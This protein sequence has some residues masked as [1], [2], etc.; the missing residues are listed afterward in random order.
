MTNLHTSLIQDARTA[1]VNRDTVRSQTLQSLL[2]R[3]SNMEA[4]EMVPE[5]EVTEAPRNVLSEAEVIQALNDEIA[6][7]SQAI[8]VLQG[9]ENP[10]LEELKT[11]LAI[12][13]EYTHETP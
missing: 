9:S 6:E 10:Y 3:I 8:E 5:S 13:Q 7:V 1:L 4:V 2:A 11:K 12:L